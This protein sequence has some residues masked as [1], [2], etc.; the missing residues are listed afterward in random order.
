M[1]W[2]TEHLAV[3]SELEIIRIHS[4]FNSTILSTNEI[5]IHF[6]RTFSNTFTNFV[7]PYVM[8]PS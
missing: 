2:L 4:N 5:H 3:E 8:N 6:D 7:F 1:N